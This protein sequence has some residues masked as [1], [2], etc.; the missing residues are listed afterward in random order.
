MV[1]K[2]KKAKDNLDK[3][4]NDTEVLP[5]SLYVCVIFVTKDENAADPLEDSDST[6]V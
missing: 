2:C 5:R 6:K 3:L 4:A 1:Q